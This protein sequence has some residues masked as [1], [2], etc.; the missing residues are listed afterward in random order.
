MNEEFHTL[1]NEHLANPPKG[2]ALFD[3]QTVKEWG[4]R[5]ST[6]LAQLS[7]IMSKTTQE[8]G[9]EFAVLLLKAV[10]GSVLGDPKATTGE[11]QVVLAPG[12]RLVS[13]NAAVIR[14]GADEN[15][16]GFIDIRIRTGGA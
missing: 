9:G 16:G 7:A 11:K 12:A 15:K 4:A 8:Q 2:D 14:E 6:M 5:S 3:L 13:V 1:V 10:R